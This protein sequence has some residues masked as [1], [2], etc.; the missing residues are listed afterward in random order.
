MLLLQAALSSLVCS[1]FPVNYHIGEHYRMFAEPVCFWRIALFNVQEK[2]F[3]V[4]VR[5]FFVE[6][7]RFAHFIHSAIGFCERTYKTNTVFIFVC[8]TIYFA[9]NKHLFERRHFCP[10]TSENKE[11]IP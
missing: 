8:R 1:Y 11:N 9:V 5:A 2:H 4:I 3:P 7:N 6:G 10:Q